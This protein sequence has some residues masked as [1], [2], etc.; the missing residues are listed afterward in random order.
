MLGRGQWL[1]L[2]DYAQRKEISL[3]TLRRY[4]KAN[5]VTYKL[6]NG[7]YLLLDEAESQMIAPVQAGGPGFDSFVEKFS[8]QHSDRVA[9]LDQ[10]KSTQCELQKTKKEVA[11][12]KTLIAYYEE[13]LRKTSDS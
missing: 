4:I 6:E 13:R 12:L 10:L 2:M 8:Q 3:S 7:R 1:S 5:K 11:E 9:L